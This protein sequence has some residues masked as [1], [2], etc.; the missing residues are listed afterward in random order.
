M[1]RADRT[2][3]QYQ[4]N[5]LAPGLLA[6]IALFLAPLLIGGEWFLL[7]RFVV[8]IL[9]LIVA[10][11]AVQA[12]QWWWL[13]VFAAIAVLWNPI[14]PFDFTGPAWTAAQPVAAIVFLVAGA[15]IKSPRT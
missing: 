11:F 15:T 4:R 9:A 10:W 13:P 7:I 2:T 12:R 14:L 6:A 8:A 1:S 5:A 3:P